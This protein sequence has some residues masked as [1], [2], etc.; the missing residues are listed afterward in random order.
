MGGQ[1]ELKWKRLCKFTS[2]ANVCL[3]FIINPL[4]MTFKNIPKYWLD[5]I[6]KG[7]KKATKQ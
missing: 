6:E 5:E 2:V 3:H 7:G 1:A 4:T